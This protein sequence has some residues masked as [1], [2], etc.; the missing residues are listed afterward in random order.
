MDTEVLVSLDGPD[1]F[2][3][4]QPNCLQQKEETQFKSCNLPKA[5]RQTPIWLRPNACKCT[6]CEVIETQRY[7]GF[8]HE[9]HPRAFECLQQKHLMQDFHLGFQPGDAA[10]QSGW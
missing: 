8:N 6:H 4:H 9:I 2:L 10:S 5:P 1:T 7:D 3:T